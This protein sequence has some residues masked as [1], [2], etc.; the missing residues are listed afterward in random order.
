MMENDIFSVS[1]YIKKVESSLA[2][3]KDEN[4]DAQ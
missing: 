3:L 4:S 1:K 2:L